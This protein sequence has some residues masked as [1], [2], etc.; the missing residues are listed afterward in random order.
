MILVNLDPPRS[1]ASQG[2]HVLRHRAKRLLSPFRDCLQQRAG[3]EPNRVVGR[4]PG[5]RRGLGDRRTRSSLVQLARVERDAATRAGRRGS[6]I[7]SCSS[8]SSAQ[9]RQ[10]MARVALDLGRPGV[11][12]EDEGV[13]CR[14][15]DQPERDARVGRMG[16]RAL[17]LDEQQLAAAAGPSTTS[18]SAAPARKSDT[19]ASTAMP[20]PAIA[21]PV[22]PVGTKTDSSPRR[23]PRGRARARRS[24][25]RSRSP[26]RPSGRSARELQVLAGGDVQVGR[27]LAQVAQLDAVLAREL[28]QLVVLADELVQAALEV[29]PAAIA[30]FSSSRQAG[31][32]RP[33]WVATPTSAVVGRYAGPPRRADDRDALVS[34]AGARRVEDRD[35]R[36]GRVAKDPARGL[37]VVRVA[38]SEVVPSG[39]AVIEVTALRGAARRSC[40]TPRSGASSGPGEQLDAVDE[41]DARPRI[42]DSSRLPSRSTWSNR[43]AHRRRRR[44][45]GRTRSCSRASRRGRAR[46]PR[47]P[48]G[49]PRGSRPTS[50][51]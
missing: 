40:V 27:R 35:R 16:E 11:V 48:F 30:C 44:C 8:T 13:R 31:G 4:Q 41:L 25:C 29:R 32:K 3:A 50:R 34:L 36:V 12:A 39:R 20:Q 51:A 21:M 19:T 45:R 17:A 5:L 28:D 14:A 6:E 49:P 23:E 26:S 10:R 37:T 2:S 33:P 22:W 24:S 46:G 38:A 1:A 18:R 7:R 47:A 9:G 43:L 15:V 42:V